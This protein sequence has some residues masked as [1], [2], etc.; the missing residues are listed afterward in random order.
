[1]LRCYYYRALFLLIPY[2]ASAQSTQLWY[3]QP[4]EK[5]TDALPIGNG[6]LGA[7]IF[8][9]VHEDRIQFNEETLWTGQP[10]NY[11]RTD[12]KQYLP[13]IRE[14]L[15]QGKQKEAETLAET[16]FM[17]LKSQAGNQAEWLASIRAFKGINADPT[18]E[19]FDDKAWKKMPVPSYEGWEACGFEGLDGA[20][21]LR[22]TLTIS[23]ALKGKSIVVDLNRIREQDF[24]YVNGQLIG[25]S[26][27]FDPRKYVI[28]A[29]LL[30]VGN[31]TLAILV[32]NYAE[33]G[34]IAGYKDTTKHIGYYPIGQEQ[35]KISLNGLWKYY[36]QNDEPPATEKYQADYQPFGDLRLIFAPLKN[37][38]SYKRSLNLENATVNTTFIANGVHYQRSYFASQPQQVIA[39]HLTADK[40]KHIALEAIFESPHKHFITRKINDN[41][42]ALS[43]KVRNGVLNGEAFLHIQT[44]NGIVKIKDGKVSITQ[45]DEVTLYLTAA[46]NFVNYQDVSG[47][48]MARCETIIANLKQKNFTQIN[49][50]HQREYQS[51]YHQLAINLGKSSYQNL[52][53]NQRLAAFATNND[54]DLA[55]LYLQ[56]GRYLLI[57]S[58]RPNTQPANLQGIWNDLLSPPWGSKYTTNVNVEMNYW[59]AEVL[60]L[61]T[62]H[63]PLL[64][65]IQELS[66]SGAETANNYYNARGWLVHHNTDIWRGTAPINAANHGIWVSGGGWLSQ[67]LWEHYLFTKDQVFLR[68]TGYPLMKS[69]ALFFV[70]FL[71]KDPKTGWLV[72][73][74]G[75]SPEQGGLVIGATMDHQ[76]IRTLFKNCIRASEILGIDD[77]FRDTLKMKVG[78]IAPNQ[79][80]KYG[81][82][83][84]WLEDKDDIENKHRHVSHLWGV[85]PG[86]DINFEDSPTLMQAAKQSLMYRGD[87]G[88]GW[89]LAWKINFWARFKEG[90]HALK[91]IKMLL[92]PASGA[93]GSYLNL[94][95]AHPPFQ[96]DGNFGGAA[97]IA[98]MLLQ[99]QGKYLDILPAL[100]TDW[101]EGSV[102]GMKARGGFT[103]DFAWKNGKLT[104]LTIFSKTPN[105]CIIRYGNTE[106][107]VH[108]FKGKLTMK[109]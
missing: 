102:R 100:P 45:A 14:L 65:M 73:S 77:A 29:N 78:Q 81:Q 108:K 12:A 6:R 50:N 36:I 7:M 51:Y 87:E 13:Q 106:K 62:L 68:K 15:A 63:E 89:S 25:S 37:Y 42:I 83:Q 101:A 52:P 64:K 39:V 67:H 99:S 56:F 28:P 96:I 88:T 23:E 66:I 32:I 104:T 103:I 4:A 84:E 27:N 11:N 18:Q 20:V 69:A 34:G 86:N 49:Q 93:G 82:L 74:L 46:T 94:F 35:D 44:K 59:A 9:G 26:H 48:P 85:Y 98:E 61:S 72:S 24:T 21:W 2:V 10:R 17:G 71:I 109:F 60:N 1:M 19:N 58:S 31:N 76:I 43:V 105:H 53:T 55:A 91:M 33:K 40:A 38:S 3:Q 57:S 79:I 22:T 97:G 70:D 107:Y 80:G 92:R 16:H 5:W 30:K 95:D 75:N 41:T 8:G 90:N 47:N 54:P